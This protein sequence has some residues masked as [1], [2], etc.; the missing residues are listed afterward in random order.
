MEGLAHGVE[1]DGD[2][3]AVDEVHL[4]AP[5]RAQRLNAEHFDGDDS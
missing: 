1:A 2:C 4:A 5:H 3:G